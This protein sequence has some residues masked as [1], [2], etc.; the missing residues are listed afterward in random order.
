[1]LNK[2]GKYEIRRELG[3]GAM[4]IVYEG[5]DPLI[6][7]AVAIKTIQKSRVSPAEASAILGRFRREAQAA[8][9]LAHPSIVS[10][11]EYGEEGDIAFIVMELLAGVELKEYFDNENHFQIKDSANIMFQLLDALEYSHSRG[12]V[13]RDL[14]PSNILITDEEKIKIADFGI[15]KIDSAD[16]TQIGNVMGTPSYMSPEQFKGETVDRRSDIYSAGVILYQLLTST[17]PFSG[18]NMKMIMHKV[19]NQEPDNPSELV[20][21]GITKAMDE[22]VRKAMAKKPEA[23]F[24]TAAEFKKALKRAMAPPTTTASKPDTVEHTEV[25]IVFKAPAKQVDTKQEAFALTAAT[26]FDMADFEK[27]FA[28]T[29][30]ETS[31]VLRQ[32]ASPENEAAFDPVITINIPENAFDVPSR[33]HPQQPHKEPAKQQPES[34]LLAK[35]AREAKENLDSKLSLDQDKQAKARRVH[36]ALERIFR[37]FSPFIQHVNNIEHTI[38]KNYRLDARTAYTNLEWRGATIDSRKL[39]TLES[40]HLAYVVFNLKLLSP[41]PVVIKRPWNQFEAVKKEL[42]H[43][44]LNVLDDL[45]ELYKKQQQEW[46]QAKLD[47]ILQIQILFKGNYDNTRIDIASLNLEELGSDSF[48]LEPEEITPEFLEEL[49]LFLI[50]R[51]DKLPVL[52]RKK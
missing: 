50:D 46:L 30:Q 22:V 19:I 38:A 20:V 23:R 18:S 7:R 25:P 9:R 12:V 24:Q 51:T 15:A 3:R 1:M 43:L 48:K 11:F 4:G 42:Q 2:L 37:F 39:S 28:E 10:I 8:G 49:G 29:Q 27:R 47:P 34:G 6:G 32:S 36:D 17:L 41:Q 33:E 14:K 13:H 52:L 5:Y 31:R 21:S 44:R 45:N 35:L 26:T 16:I 40:A